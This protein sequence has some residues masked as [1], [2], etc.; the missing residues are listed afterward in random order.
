MAEYRIKCEEG[1]GYIVASY[2][3]RGD[4]SLCLGT[5]A[6]NEGLDREQVITIETIE[7]NKQTLSITALVK[8]KG[9]RHRMFLSDNKL[10][11]TSDGLDFCVLKE[12]K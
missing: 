10:F 2:K 7:E 8:Q 9:K 11:K 4:E 1:D 6:P 3:E 5:D 12:N